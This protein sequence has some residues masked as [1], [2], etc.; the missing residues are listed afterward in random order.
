MSTVIDETTGWDA[1]RVAAALDE[2][3]HDHWEDPSGSGTLAARCL[4][5]ATELGDDHLRAR[6][7]VVQGLIALNRGDLRA[8]YALVADADRLAERA[9]SDAARLEVAA[10]KSQVNFFA[11]AHTDALQQ[12]WTTIDLGERLGTRDMRIFARRGA[13]L[14]LG[15]LE[16]PGFVAELYELLRLSIA[17]GDH[18]QIAI[19]RNDIAH[20]LMLNG[21]FDDADVEL[22]Q[23]VA[24]AEELAPRNSF[25]LSVVFCTRAELRLRTDRPGDGLLDAERALE[26][27]AA[28][29]D[30]PNPYL[31]GIAT[32]L[33]VQA[34]LALGHTDQAQECGEAAVERLG[35]R[36]PQMRASILEAVATSLREAGRTG[37]AY[38]ALERGAALQR[39]ALQ[40]VAEIQRGYDRATHE[41]EAAR[42]EADALAEKDR[43]LAAARRALAE[44]QAELARL[45]AGE[46]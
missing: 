17:A 37:D 8:A 15:N 29:D 5:H 41:R 3:R 14:V 25:A 45:Q 38:D 28:A 21:E 9:D 23:A 13:C 30:E 4:Q 18:W 2:A 10:L 39:A 33:Q 24:I 26:L 16:A 36:V 19:S 40:E 44:A 42:H 27:L 35:E 32:R 43:E 31:F 7:H 20:W 12:A 46:P 1:P 6:A 11:G 34:L 22:E